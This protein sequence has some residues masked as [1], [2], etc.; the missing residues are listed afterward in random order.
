MGVMGNIFDKCDFESK[1]F[2][3][4]GIMLPSYLPEKLPFRE[5]QIEDMVSVLSAC[6]KGDRPT[7]L[8]IYGKPGTGKTSCTKYVINQLDE[9]AKKNSLRIRTIYANCRQYNSKYKV[10]SN[11]VQKLLPERDIIGYSG[12]FVYENLLAYCEKNQAKLIVAMDEIDKVKD[13]DE[14]IYALTRANEELKK[15]AISIIGISNQL[16]FKE[17]LDA[18]TKS[19]LCEKEIVFPPYNAE[20]LAEILRERVKMAF[21]KGVVDESAI[22]YAA[23]IAAQESGDARAAVMLLLRAGELAEKELLNKV[24]DVEVRKAKREVEEEIAIDMI[25]TLPEQQQLVIYAISRLTFEKRGIKRFDDEHALCS[26]EIYD[27]YKKIAARFNIAPVSI[28]WFQEYIGELETYGI[29]L[30][31][32]S[33]KGFKGQSRIIRLGLD[34]EKVKTALE[35]RFSS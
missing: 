30:T 24:T 27:E 17:R 29:I 16:T 23:A 33:G 5:K 9:F 2:E 12:T 28:R 35:K 10:L 4:R 7:N 11:V 1:I 8:F 3:N 20:E 21:K 18:R 32:N 6:T 19:S 26:G 13:L 14:L 34:V 25:S 15:G 31:T 22:K